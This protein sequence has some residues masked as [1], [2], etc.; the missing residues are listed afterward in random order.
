MTHS[1]MIPTTPATLFPA[2][3]TSSTSI[4]LSQLVLPNFIHSIWYVTLASTSNQSWD[5][6]PLHH[7]PHHPCHVVPGDVHLLHVHPTVT[8]GLTKLCTCLSTCRISLYVNP[9]LRYPPTPT[10]SPAPSP[11]RSWRRTWSWP[12]LTTPLETK[13]RTVKS[14]K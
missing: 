13:Q 4:P 1:T 10:W 12:G 14:R 8:V 9:E 6:L 2:T 3:S 5:I 7:D 11:W